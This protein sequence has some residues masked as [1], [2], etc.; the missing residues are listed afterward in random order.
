MFFMLRILIKSSLN[1][2]IA[3]GL[4]NLTHNDGNDIIENIV[5]RAGD[6]KR[7]EARLGVAYLLSDK[8]HLGKRKGRGKR[9]IFNKRYDL[10]RNARNYRFYDLGKN[11][12]YKCLRFG[13]A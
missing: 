9:S 1:L 13:I 2:I 7:C 4:F 5:E 11:Y 10:V 12:S 8:E 3:H 6:K